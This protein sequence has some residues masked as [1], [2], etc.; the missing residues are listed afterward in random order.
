MSL[1]ESVLK[2]LEA[3]SCG[4]ITVRNSDGWYTAKLTVSY[5]YEGHNYSNTVSN[6]TIGV[7]KSLNIP[8]GASEISAKCEEMWGFGWSTIFN[9]H[10]DEPVTKCYKIWGTTLNPKY[11][12]TKC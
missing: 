5:K 10:F 11:E 8:C 7:T 9:K 3:T 1:K 6:I 2:H 4:S 12:E